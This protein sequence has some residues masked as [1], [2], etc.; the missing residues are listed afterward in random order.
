MSATTE[1]LLLAIREQ[2]K[3]LRLDAAS[4]G[5]PPVHLLHLRQ[6]LDWCSGVVQAEGKSLSLEH[7]KQINEDLR[8][9]PE[10]IAQLLAEHAFDQA[11]DNAISIW[12]T[13][14]LRRPP[15]TELPVN[16][17]NANGLAS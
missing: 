1:G 4:F 17:H 2:V 15:P 13:G 7:L 11:E 8:A 9:S 10:A 16:I 12:M 14:L 3:A 6:A 5:M